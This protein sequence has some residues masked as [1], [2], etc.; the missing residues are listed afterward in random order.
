MNKLFKNKYLSTSIRLQSWDYSWDG[1][2]FI[3]IC[4]Q[5]MKHYFGKINTDDKMDFTEGGK[6]A[7]QIWELIPSQFPFVELDEF[8]IMPNHMH[9]LL[10]LN[11]G[12]K[13]FK[14]DTTKKE[15]TGGG[16]TGNKNPMLHEN[17]SRV[18]RWYKGRVSFEIR[19]IMNEN[20]DEIS[21][22]NGGHTFQWQPKF[23]D[24]I[25]HTQDRFYNTSKYIIDN[26]KKW[27]LMKK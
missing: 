3:T 1:I 25:I 22:Q 11:N 12:N 9:G 13:M 16:V 23:Y 24:R 10:I 26:P 4:T 21:K 6:I 15:I 5:N 17:I 2:Y 20:N 27:N 8:I 19:K 14:T 18:I 7:H